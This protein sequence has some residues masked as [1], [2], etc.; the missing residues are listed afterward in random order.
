M[1]IACLLGSPRKNGNSAVLARYFLA[2]AE[3][4][5]ATAS[6]HDLNSLQMRGCQACY[7]CKKGSEICVVQDDLAPVLDDVFNADLVLMAAPIYYSDVSAQLKMFI[8]RTFAYL[9]P[10]YIAREKKTRFAEQ[11]KTLFILTQGHRDPE[12]FSDILPRYQKILSWPGFDIIPV[13]AVD[14]YFEGDV[15]KRADL[16]AELDR[17]AEQL[18]S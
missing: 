6:V 10:G 11:K 5:G 3:T 12:M 7:A 16:F 15:E 2:A 18:C 4:F 17:L 13:R 8:D 14:V 9:V 1:H